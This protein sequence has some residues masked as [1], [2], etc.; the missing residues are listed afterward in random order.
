MDVYKI[1]KDKIYPNYSKRTS[2]KPI[3]T[4]TKRRLKPAI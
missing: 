1:L 2:A 3:K 4:I